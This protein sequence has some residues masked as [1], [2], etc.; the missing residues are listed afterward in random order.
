[1]AAKVVGHLPGIGR[2]APLQGPAHFF[3]ATASGAGPET[4]ADD[5]NPA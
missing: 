3:V 2:S 5:I 4:T 1:M